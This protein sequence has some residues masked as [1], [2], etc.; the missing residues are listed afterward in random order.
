MIDAP[1]PHGGVVEHGAAVGPAWIRA[2]QSVDADAAREVPSGP[3]AFDGYDAALLSIARRD[4]D[5][6]RT[7]L[8]AKL[9]GFA[10]GDSQRNAIVRMEQ[11]CRPAFALQR[12]RR[13]GERGV[14]KRTCWS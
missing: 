2:R 13:L 12:A 4:V 11:R 9:D 5:D 7:A 3:E 10:C 6:D 14:E 1:D 8:V